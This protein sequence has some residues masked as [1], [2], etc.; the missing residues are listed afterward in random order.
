M[1]QIHQIHQRLQKNNF[2][3]HT[4]DLEVGVNTITRLNL[5]IVIIL[6]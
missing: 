5:V 1:K 4:Y 3:S 2:L 6:I